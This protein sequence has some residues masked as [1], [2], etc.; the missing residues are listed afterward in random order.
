MTKENN[1]KVA[2][3]LFPI[4][5]IGASAGGLE[6]ATMLL[7]ALPT[8]LGM[9]FV[10]VQHLDPTH[11]SI[12]ADL[13]SKATTLPVEEARD[14][15]QVQPNHV[16]VI[17]HNK[18]MTIRAG[19]LKLTARGARK[20][21]HMPIDQFL[22]SLAESQNEKAI[23]IILSGTASDGTLGLK[24]IKIAGGITFAQDE[25]AKYQGMPKA[26]ISSGNVDF[27][28]SPGGI[29][30]ELTKMNN[31]PYIKQ[32]MP[33]EDQQELPEDE[34]GLKKIFFML[35]RGSGIDFRHY[36]GA[37]INRRIRRRML[38]H[39][40]RSFKEYIEY[41]K[42]N[43]GE[44]ESLH[45]DLLINVT[46]FFREPQSFQFLHDKIFPIMIKNRTT[47]EPIRVWVP[48]CATGE[49]VY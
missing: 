30:K 44:I 47:K 42:E 4:V 21:L 40:L 6:A 46:S 38:L 9:G 37:T 5:G 12:L 1:G 43:S 36:K 25:T 33:I 28:L 19:V 27:V 20:K 31:H 18:D 3:M 32:S 13:L 11:E 22:R 49:E 15:T 41:L 24:A 8:N 17:P 7:K 2:K 39:K 35:R 45:N 48:G 16:Y 34:D 26:A 10:L 14:N 23:G 29:A